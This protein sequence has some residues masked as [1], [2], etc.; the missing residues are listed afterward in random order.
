MVSPAVHSRM[1][2]KDRALSAFPLLQL[3][4]SCLGGEERRREGEEGD[5]G[6]EEGRGDGGKEEGRG[7]GGRGR[8]EGEGERKGGGEEWEDFHLLWQSIFT[9]S[10]VNLALYSS[11]NV[12]Q[13]NQA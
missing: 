6:K 1:N 10:K 8:G 4:I 11:K 7:D 2:Q 12:S 13:M 3:V 9:F 5:G